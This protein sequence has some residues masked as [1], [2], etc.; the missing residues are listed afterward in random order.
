[1]LTVTVE[2]LGEVA[3][4]RCLGRIVHGDE[5]AILCPAAQQHGRSVIVDLTQ[6]D[7]IDAAGIGALVALQAA[8]V[9]LTL[10]NPNQQVRELLKV[11]KLDSIFEIRECRPVP[12]A[13]ELTQ[14]DIASPL[15]AGL[16][17]PVV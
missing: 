17:M 16:Q 3:I 9:Y 10:M 13:G 12:E 8:G 14:A 15:S 7:A 4:L 2:N 1:M 5:T 6:V 11:T